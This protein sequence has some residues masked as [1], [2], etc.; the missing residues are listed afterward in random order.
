MSILNPT[1]RTAPQ[2]KDVAT[3][4]AASLKIGSAV[5]E[6]LD[7]V[8]QKTDIAIDAEATTRTTNDGIITTAL[9]THISNPTGAHAAS[10]ISNI[11]AGTVSST[12]VQS[13]INE[14]ATD[15]ASAVSGEATLRANADTALGSRIDAEIAQLRATVP[16]GGTIV[17]IASS[18]A[19]RIDNTQLRLSNGS[20][21]SD[22][23]GATINFLTAVTTGNVSSFSTINFTGNAS[24]YAKYSLVLLATQPDS[25]LVISGTT[26]YSTFSDAQN[27]TS[28]P[29]V[30][31]GIPI[32]TVI[33]QDNG[34]GGTT[35]LSLSQSNIIQYK[36]S[37]GG[38]PGLTAGSPLNIDQESNYAFYARSDFSVDGVLFANPT[39]GA[40]F[41]GGLSNQILGLG[42]I[43]FTSNTG[44]FA[45][46]N[47]VGSQLQS[48]SLRINKASV[49]LLYENNYTEIPTLSIS[50]DGGNTYNSVPD[51]KLTTKGNMVIGDYSFISDDILSSGTL[52]TPQ[53]ATTGFAAIV[54]PVYDQ[55]L[56][57]FDFYLGSSTSGTNAIGYLYAISGGAPTGSPLVTCP[58]VKAL[59]V[60]ITST[61]S[62]SSFTLPN[63]Y[64]LLAGVSYAL[65]V[66]TTGIGTLTTDIVT[67]A[68]P[69]IISG[70]TWNGTSWAPNANKY[71]VN[72][73]SSGIDLRIKV[74]SSGVYT[75]NT[76]AESHLKGFGIDFVWQGNYPIT[77]D[78]KMETRVI[79]SIEESTGLVTLQ[80]VSFTPGAGQLK[81]YSDGRVFSSTQFVEL[82]SNQV[83]FPLDV[84]ASSHLLA[85]DIVRFEAS[86][87]MVDGSSISLSK[88]NLIYDAIVGSAAQVVAGIAQY[89][90]INTA[91]NSVPTGSSVYILPGTYTENIVMP[92][93]KEL[94][95]SGKGRSSVINGTWIFSSGVSY[96]IV[97]NLRITG[98]IAFSGTGGGNFFR[99]IFIPSSVVVNDLGVG[100]SKLIMVE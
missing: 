70:T 94:N 83:Q 18:I 71:A 4:S 61:A 34:S 41:S 32:A 56:T 91:L 74:Q 95:I 11:P 38:S 89:T 29:A 84:F 50:R 42:R 100:N 87:G 92:L 99:K 62:Y 28:D 13:A 10:A 54:S 21:A 46:S 68:S 45:T 48:E 25:I 77:G 19:T 35:I 20:L 72:L 1:G 78:A 3:T 55:V 8:I 81:V 23:A 40:T 26:F 53:S 44:V 59:G 75:G 5:R 69:W 14:L 57:S 7:S 2:T 37:G 43:K 12:D 24:K 67:S 58:Q 98:N 22:F 6:D 60:D 27:D 88:L 15:Y 85:G 93:S 9:N 17:T 73:Y 80:G 39:N 97:E 64:T 33:V 90:S 52:S 51:A 63:G 16:G 66:V 31:G 65:V 49:R 76:S 96:C 36:A 86:Y 82:S 47:I 30:S 79:S